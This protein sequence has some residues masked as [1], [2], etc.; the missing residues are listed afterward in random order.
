MFSMALQTCNFQVWFALLCWRHE[1]L[2]HRPDPHHPRPELDQ[3]ASGKLWQKSC[4]VQSNTAFPFFFAH[5]LKN[6]LMKIS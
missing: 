6:N 2:L 5:I 3:S 1:R 4:N